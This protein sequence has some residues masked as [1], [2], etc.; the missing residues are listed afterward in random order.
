M[1]FRYL[2]S[3][4]LLSDEQ[5]SHFQLHLLLYLTLVNH[6][7][8]LIDF[9]A[10]FRQTFILKHLQVNPLFRGLL[11][12]FEDFHSILEY[13]NLILRRFT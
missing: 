3:M 9:F 8:L 13:L 11:L 1:M 2:F 10:H 12:S 6:I 5:S 7:L 4:S